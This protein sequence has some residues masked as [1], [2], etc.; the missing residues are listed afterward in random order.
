MQARFHARI[1]DRF[2]VLRNVFCTC[3][4]RKRAD[5][6]YALTALRTPSRLRD[7][8]QPHFSKRGKNSSGPLLS[9]LGQGNGR[10]L[11]QMPEN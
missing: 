1:H 3:V 11:V 9:L 10:K 2:H 5:F 8:Q 6:R 4:Y 7:R